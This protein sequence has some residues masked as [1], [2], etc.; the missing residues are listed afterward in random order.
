MTTTRPLT[1]RM[2]EVVRLVEQ[3]TDE[4]GHAPAMAEVGA[5]L[6]IHRTTALRLARAAAARGAMTF[7]PGSPR[8]WVVAK[9]EKAARI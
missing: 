9:K 6:G 3:L 1:P 4:L 7:V 8:T 2:L 5:A